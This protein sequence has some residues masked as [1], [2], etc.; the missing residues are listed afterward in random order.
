MR[1]NAGLGHEPMNA[2]EDN[3]FVT[4][5]QFIKTLPQRAPFMYFSALVYKKV[6]KLLQ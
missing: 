3:Q 4:G 6:P 1:K 5:F 2:I